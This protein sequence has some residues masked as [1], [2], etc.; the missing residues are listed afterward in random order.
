MTV[1]YTQLEQTGQ[2][3]RG[4][5]TVAA[6]TYGTLAC[7]FGGNPANST[8]TTV[9]QRIDEYFQKHLEDNVVKD[10]YTATIKPCLGMIDTVTAT[11]AA[12]ASGNTAVVESYINA[13]LLPY[14]NALI[15]AV[16]YTL[17]FLSNPTGFIMTVCAQK[18]TELQREFNLPSFPL[19]MPTTVTGALEWLRGVNLGMLSSPISEAGAY[20]EKQIKALSDWIS[21]HTAAT[22]KPIGEVL[23]KLK[24]IVPA[25]MV[26][27]LKALSMTYYLRVVNILREIAQIMADPFGY[28]IN[29]WIGQELKAAFDKFVEDHFPETD[30]SPEYVA[31]KEKM[32]A[33]YQKYTNCNVSN[34]LSI[35]SFG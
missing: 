26:A 10:F 16:Q 31:F 7:V 14:V 34:L 23:D 30:P 28:I 25:D 29:G 15:K 13:S 18:Y 17:Q 3:V 8:N 12:V 2:W 27:D 4:T 22:F 24:D 6:S 33:A 35:F 32:K 19:T 1:T 9:V 5:I 20:T 21:A 11:A